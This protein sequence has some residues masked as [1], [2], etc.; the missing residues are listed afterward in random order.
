MYRAFGSAV[1]DDP[2]RV[3]PKRSEI[4][5]FKVKSDQPKG[6][7]RIST[8][9]SG[10]PTGGNPY[11][12]R[13]AIVPVGGRATVSTNLSRRSYSTDRASN[14]SSRLDYLV[15]LSKRSTNEPIRMKI[16]DILS[17]PNFLFHAY[18][19][20]KS[21]PGNMTRG[22]SN[23]TLDGVSGEFFHKLA[24]KLK[25]EKFQFSQARRIQI[26]KPAGGTRP[27]TIAPPRDKI[28]QEG[29]RI[30]LNAIFEPTFNEVSH[31]LRPHRSCHT[32]LKYLKNH[33]QPS[34]WFIE[35]DISKCFPSIDHQGLMKI[36]ES[37]ILDRKFTKLI[38]KSLKAGY[39]EFTEYKQDMAG[40]P[41]G[42]II[43]P[44]LSNVFLHQLDEFVLSLKA[45]FDSGQRSKAPRRSRIIN[46]YIQRAKKT[47]DMDRVRE[48]VR[49]Y[50]GLPGIDY[51]DPLYKRLSY[52]RYADDWVIGIRGSHKDAAA[53][54]SKVTAFCAEIGLTI[55][56]DKTKITSVIS[57]KVKFLGTY[58][59][60]S[61][62]VK[63]SSRK[64]I[65]AR[66][67]RK[68]LFLAPMDRIKRKL[69]EANFLRY[70]KAHPKFLW[71]HL[72]HDQIIHLYNSVMRGFA[73]YYSFASNYGKLAG[74]LTLI[75]K[76][77]CCK[78][79]AT[80]F[81]LGTMKTTYIK[82]TG[83]LTSP[84]GNRFVKL[85]YKI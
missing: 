41:Q 10:L 19:N 78:L 14:V 43:S 56:Q 57:D 4:I 60:R 18:Q 34:T 62:H 37:K 29:M 15:K 16:Y 30:V 17:N 71:L 39:F 5:R 70:G 65:K 31:G 59:T 66:L 12:N 35:G 64:S 81:N 82:F 45:E 73:N 63:F 50:R 53:A 27:L 22:V 58:I 49:E 67:S 23:T 79:L 52:V 26:P 69:K 48:L 11:G 24:T 44:I 47:G 13:V 38:W 80:K 9:S 54:L 20:I 28:V 68:L 21:K 25:S 46:Q 55:N 1:T 84:K 32:A 51:H 85:S 36:I 61:H 75:L 77:S 42:S 74:Y 7:T 40:T 3:A 76:R 72:N 8:W 6:S 83:D 33:F 2:K